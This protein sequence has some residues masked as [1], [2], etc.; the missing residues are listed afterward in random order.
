ML[1][2]EQ[3]AQAIIAL[4]AKINIA[5][6]QDRAERS[7]ANMSDPDK[8]ETQLVHK[9]ICGGFEEEFENDDG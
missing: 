2:A 3:G 8:E 7:W 6:P 1:S 4:Q 9:Q 5:E